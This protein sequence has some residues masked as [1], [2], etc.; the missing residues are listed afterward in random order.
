MVRTDNTNSVLFLL[1]VAPDANKLGRDV[2]MRMV[3]ELWQEDPL[4]V[5][6]SEP[7]TTP[8]GD[9]GDQEDPWAAFS[10]LRR[11]GPD[12]LRALGAV[13]AY[14]LRTLRSHRDSVPLHRARRAD[15]QTIAALLRSPAVRLF[16]PSAEES[17]DSARNYRVDIPRVEE[18]VDSAA[19]RTTLA[20]ILSLLRRTRALGERLQRLVEGE[21]VSATRT[22]LAT[23]WPQRKQF[24]E[25]LAVQL[26]IVL[27]LDPFAQVQRADVTA[28]GL[29][30][31]AADPV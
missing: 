30:A 3:N 19:N 16:A 9:L 26:K 21:N 8:N 6:G 22:S 18:T 15:R 27:R 28:A 24:L 4:L 11:Y 17:P 12:V 23:R 25:S 10:R 1:D 20:L 14:P 5:I 31:I 7:A 13:R 29:T 2:F